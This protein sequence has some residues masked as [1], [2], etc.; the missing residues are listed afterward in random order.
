MLVALIMSAAAPAAAPP[1]GAARPVAGDLAAA[2][3]IAT[4]TIRGH[5]AALRTA[6]PAAPA[7]AYRL[8]VEA[9]RDDAGQWIAYQIRVSGGRSQLG[10]G[11]LEFRIDRCTGAVSRLHH[12]R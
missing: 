4:S 11:G 7:A 3:R 8:I 1:C 9:D 2:R 12:A 5:E 10:G 6:G